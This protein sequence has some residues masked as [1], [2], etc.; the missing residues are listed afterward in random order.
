MSKRR[1]RFLTEA[2]G[3]LTAGYLIKAVQEAGHVCIASDIDE[4]CFGRELAD[5]FLLMPRSDDAQL[6]PK[7]RRLLVEG[8][9]EVVIPSLDETLLAWSQ[10]Q[11][12]LRQLG[13]QVVVSTAQAVAICQD[14]WRTYEF[15]VANGV[16]TP[17]TS[18]QQEYPLV[19]PRLGR[20][21]NGVRTTTEPVDMSGML[22]QELLTGVEY[23]VDV[24]CDRDHQ[25]VY[26]VPRRRLRVSGG[27]STG[28]IVERNENI[29]EWVRK[30][31]A[32]LQFVGPINLQCF[33]LA[34]GSVRFVE[35]NPRI[36]GGMALGFAATENWIDLVVRNI[37][38]GEA[39]AARRI[40]YGLE[41]RRYYAEVFVPAH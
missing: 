25:P 32:R 38:H 22:S 15:F 40:R 30:I 6:W 12:D 7:M 1:Y 16:P 13:V 37:L 20:G 34:D 27:K 28:G 4:R 11:H 8:R 33:V 31:C 24:F 2:S 36:A 19:K 14:K 10:Q 23:T 35:I 3:S 5:E 21:G 9:V 29:D 18:L 17:A 39:I 41:M 26:V